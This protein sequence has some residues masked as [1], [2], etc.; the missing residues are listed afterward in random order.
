MG[1]VISLR[2]YRE[3]RDPASAALGRLDRAVSRLDPLVRERA[4]A[5]TLTIERELLVIARA[6]ADGSPERA[7]DRAERL[8]GI[9]EHPA[10]SG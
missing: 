2:W 9:L 5:L 6:V 1:E 10:A 3:R 7:A 8:A 4:G